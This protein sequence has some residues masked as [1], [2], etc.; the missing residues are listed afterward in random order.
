[1]NAEEIKTIRTNTIIKINRQL[2]LME[3]SNTV[4]IAQLENAIQAP[5][6]EAFRGLSKEDSLALYRSISLITHPDKIRLQRSNDEDRQTFNSHMVTLST[7]LE[8]DDRLRF[9]AIAQQQV[10]HCYKGDQLPTIAS[11]ASMNPIDYIRQIRLGMNRIYRQHEKVYLRY[12]LPIQYLIDALQYI[13]NAVLFLSTVL[14]ALIKF[15]LFFNVILPKMVLSFLPEAFVDVIQSYVFVRLHPGMSQFL[16]QVFIGSNHINTALNSMVTQKELADYYRT[17]FTDHINLADESDEITLRYAAKKLC[18]E[19]APELEFE[20]SALFE[21]DYIQLLNKYRET[22]FGLK[23]AHLLTLA[24]YKAMETPAPLPVELVYQKK[25]GETASDGGWCI[26]NGQFFSLFN[27]KKILHEMES[28]TMDSP[29]RRQLPDPYICT[30]HDVFYYDDGKETLIRL[31]LNKRKDTDE[32]MNAQ[33]PDLYICY[34]EHLFFYNRKFEQIHRINTDDSTPVQT[35]HATFSNK[36]NGPLSD[37]DLNIIKALPGH[38]ALE[39][40]TFM[41]EVGLNLLTLFR[42]VFFVPFLFIESFTMISQLILTALFTTWCYT[43]FAIK[44]GVTL[45]LNSPLYLYDAWNEHTQDAQ[46]AFT[47][48]D[49]EALRC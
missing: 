7:R 12:S 10:E 4:S 11:M 49:S 36:P 46:P 40:S 22:F 13:V 17:Y 45:L 15:Y 26:I 47:T 48:N 6:R 23:Y 27:N 16:L 25:S 20:K 21:S 32:A 42:A 39:Q 9:L 41:M 37:D 2:S 8:P 35:F 19:F 24:F 1:M 33:K 3:Q 29:E 43:M 18:H 31:E 14:F 34:G 5:I 30:E 44:L 38:H 28:M